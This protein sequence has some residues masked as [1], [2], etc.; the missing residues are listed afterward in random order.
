[1]ISVANASLDDFR[2]WIATVSILLD[3]SAMVIML[4]GAV[5]IEIAAPLA[6]QLFSFLRFIYLDVGGAQLVAPDEEDALAIVR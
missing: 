5:V 3:Y 2:N 4:I 6:L 1:M